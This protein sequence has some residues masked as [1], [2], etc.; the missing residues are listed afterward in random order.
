MIPDYSTSHGNRKLK[1]ITSFLMDESSHL[2]YGRRIMQVTTQTG[3][4][5]TL[6]MP[7]V[8]G[9][10]KVPEY[11]DFPYFRVYLKAIGKDQWWRVEEF[12][13]GL[14]PVLAHLVQSDRKIAMLNAQ[15]EARL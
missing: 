13:A 11:Q 15:A 2:R 6:V 14:P 7:F 9:V 8:F 1:F 4:T 5:V 12:K 10:E 3:E